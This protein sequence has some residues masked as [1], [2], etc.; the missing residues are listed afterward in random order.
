MALARVAEVYVAL[1]CKEK[2]YGDNGMGLPKPK[3]DE[4]ME[5]ARLRADDAVKNEKMKN[6]EY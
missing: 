3:V 2:K 6:I 5:V 4:L 1:K